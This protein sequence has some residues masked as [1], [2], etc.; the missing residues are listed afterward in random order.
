M[1]LGAGDEGRSEVRIMGKD[2]FKDELQMRLTDATHDRDLSAAIAYAICDGAGYKE[3]P[4]PKV[5]EVVAA[6]KAARASELAQEES[7]KARRRYAYAAREMPVLSGKMGAEGS[8]RGEEIPAFR[9]LDDFLGMLV[10]PKS[11]YTQGAIITGA[12]GIGKT[13]RVVGKLSNAGVKYTIFNSYSTPLATYESLYRHNGECIVF[14]DTTG[15]LQDKK[16]VAIL[17]AALFSATGERLITYSST[18][19]VLQERGIPESFIFTGRIIIILNE[20]PATLKESFQALLSRVYHHDVKLT[21]DEKRRLV[22]HVFSSDAPELAALDEGQRAELLKMLT[23]VLD[24][25]N[26]HRFNVRTALRAAEIYSALGREKAQ[27]LIFNLLDVDARL[28]HFLLIEKYGANEN[29][30]KRVEAFCSST[31]YS[32]RVYFDIKAKYYGTRYGMAQSNE[33]QENEV[34]YL[35]GHIGG[36]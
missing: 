23:D 28:R 16:S 7:V 26:A 13:K 12:A 14:D 19:K 34:R 4:A 36:N 5:A 27:E 30:Q 20:I 29:V 22:A 2:N 11:T 32:R 31:G 17:K 1:Q 18:A 8:L 3:I 6:A 10:S 24:F 33:A 9:A 21:L 35:F 25:S 15:I